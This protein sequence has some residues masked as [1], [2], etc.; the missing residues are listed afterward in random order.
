MAETTFPRIYYHP[1]EPSRIFESQAELDAAGPGWVQTP[2]EAADAAASATPPAP[3]T[4]DEGHTP[5]RSRR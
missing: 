3:P 5:P 2:T 4:E 1:T